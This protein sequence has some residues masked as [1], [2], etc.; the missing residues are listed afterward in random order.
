MKTGED[1]RGMKRLSGTAPSWEV[2]RPIGTYHISAA[3]STQWLRSS[4]K[5]RAK[6]RNHSIPMHLLFL[7]WRQIPKQQP[8][9]VT[10]ANA[11]LWRLIQGC[12]SAHVLLFTELLRTHQSI[13]AFRRFLVVAELLH[14]VRGLTKDFGRIEQTTS[15]KWTT[16]FPLFHHPE[17]HCPRQDSMRFCVR[18]PDEHSL[19]SLPKQE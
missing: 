7:R 3:R 8:C 18:K 1:F 15:T 19:S 10:R 2:P 5:S 9:T 11:T 12:H 13:N 16:S 14:E 6:S 17:A 4:G